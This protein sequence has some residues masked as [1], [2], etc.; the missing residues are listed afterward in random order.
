MGIHRISGPET[1]HMED[2]TIIR[3]RI[4]IRIRIRIGI[5][6]RICIRIRIRIRIQCPS[7]SAELMEIAPNLQTCVTVTVLYHSS[8]PTKVNFFTAI[9]KL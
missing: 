2:Q 7:V 9:R 3:I 6:I 8:Y 4:G 1:T 5:R